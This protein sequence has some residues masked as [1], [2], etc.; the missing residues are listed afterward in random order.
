VLHLLDRAALRV[1]SGGPRGVHPLPPQ[2]EHHHAE[3]E[4]HRAPVEV[5]VVAERA[6]VD[7]RDA[8]EA[9]ADEDGSEE[10]E[11]QADRQPDVESHG[12]S[13]SARRR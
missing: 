6:L 7:R 3:D 11:E 10:G 2:D 12:V 13:G 8:Q 9:E 1:Q 5:D 4:Q